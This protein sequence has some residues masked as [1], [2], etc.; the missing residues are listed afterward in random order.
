MGRAVFTGAAAANA[1]SISLNPAALGESRTE[2]YIALAGLLDQL[3]ID[4]RSIDL[5]TGGLVDAGHVSDHPAGV[6]GQVGFVWHPGDFT[7]GVELRL[8]PPELFP[9]DP[10]LRYHSLGTRQRN[11]IV[12]AGT[13]LK[14]ADEFYL[15]F[16]VSHDVTKLHLR[17]ARDTALDVGLGADCGGA[18]CGL[19]NPQAAELYDVDVRSQW[20][21]ADNF[22]LNI[23]FL[24][25]PVDGVW[26]GIAY[27]NTPGAGIQTKLT[28]TMDVTRAPRDGGATLRGGS[29]VYVSYPATVDVDLRARIYRDLDLCIGGRWED[30]SRMQAYDVRG[31]G[32]AFRGQSVPEWLLRPRGFHDAFAAWGGVEQ[33]ETVRTPGTF[34]FG[35]RIGFETSALRADRTAPGTVSP[36]S[37]TLDAGVQYRARA[38]A[39]FRVSYGAQVFPRVTVDRSDY[40]PRFATDC[41]AS[42]FDYSTRACE[43][44]RNGY[45]IPTAAGDYTRIQHALRLA[46]AYEFP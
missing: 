18:A 39:H 9:D 20:I 23:G 6:G 17:Y 38:N 46:F 36:A 28:G 26:F 8:P 1:T 29:T 24:I 5:S 19:E 15:G 22:R 35:G 37:L 16:G 12:T 41:A 43:A 14:I 32:D 10:A 34:R 7:L 21:S 40:D 2:L 42:G 25:H 11:Y 4:R 31:Y 3:G 13:S 45:A 27:H 44:V 33:T 30:L